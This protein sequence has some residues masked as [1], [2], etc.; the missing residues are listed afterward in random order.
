MTQNLSGGVEQTQGLCLVC[1][2]WKDI[3]GGEGTKKKED[4]LGPEAV[5]GRDIIEDNSVDIKDILNKVL[6]HVE[7]SNY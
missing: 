4:S 3:A 7:D 2:K 5:K 1:P 6:V